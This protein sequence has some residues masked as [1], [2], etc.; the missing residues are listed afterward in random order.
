MAP[1]NDGTES[2]NPLVLSG[3]IQ[4]L[5]DNANNTDSSKIL[6]ALDFPLW[7]GS[8][9]ATA[10]ATNIA[11]WDITCGLHIFD[12]SSS[13]P[14]GDVR[15][16]V[17]GLKNSITFLHVDPEGLGTRDAIGVGGKAWGV[18][19]EH[20]GFKKS[21]INFYLDDGFCLNEVT[22]ESNYD[23]E[24]IAL[25]PG[26]CMYVIPYPISEH[27]STLL[28]R[29]MQPGIPHF[30]LGL[31]NSICYGGHHYSM[32]LMQ[33][34]LQGVIHSFMLDK[35]LMNTTHQGSRQLFRRILIFYLHGLMDKK[36]STQ[37][38]D[39]I[40]YFILANIYT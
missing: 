12:P 4:D 22:E 39:L 31:E 27:W 3:V 13:H 2:C 18:V 17:A 25:H 7:D 23:F 14:T 28:S 16:G 6:N 24:I 35:F 9:E 34:T 15:W 20:P 30:V 36:I 1:S 10:Y 32:L 8:R 29:Y 21:S 38:R 11:A 33:Q 40:T 26:D 5:L 37:G 19:Q